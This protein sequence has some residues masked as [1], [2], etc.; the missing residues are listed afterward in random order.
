MALSFLPYQQQSWEMQSLTS[1]VL[2][3]SE[4]ELVSP[5]TLTEESGSASPPSV[6]WCEVSSSGAMLLSGSPTKNN[7]SLLIQT[8]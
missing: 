4:K 7:S 3:N 6:R 2:A 5:K 1:Q 8:P